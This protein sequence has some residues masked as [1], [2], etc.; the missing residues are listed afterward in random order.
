MEQAQ[1]CQHRQHHKEVP[2]RERGSVARPWGYLRPG[3]A[4]PSSRALLYLMMKSKLEPASMSRPSKVETA[5]SV[6]GAKV[7]SRALAARRFRLPWLV[8]KP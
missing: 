3:W 8:R 2:G 6:T 7:C 1:E 5:P 4:V